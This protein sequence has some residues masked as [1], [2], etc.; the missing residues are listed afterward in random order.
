MEHKVVEEEGVAGRKGESER[1]VGGREG[2]EKD[3]GAWG[4][5]IGKNKVEKEVV[6]Q[7][8]ELDEVD[9]QGEKRVEEEKAIVIK[10]MEQ[11]V[12]RRKTRRLAKE[13]VLR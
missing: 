5:E 7:E 1:G 8:L 10:M 4:E 2:S 6:K 3:N 12:K 13:E 9:Q 11:E